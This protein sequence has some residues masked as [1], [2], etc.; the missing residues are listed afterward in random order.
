MSAERLFSADD[1]GHTPQPGRFERVRN[2]AVGVSEDGLERKPLGGTGL[3]VSALG[4]G[5][6]KLGAFWQ[7]RSPAE[8]RRAIDAARHAGINLFDT[9]D[10]YARGISER[11]LGR[12]FRGESGE[13]VLCT[14]VGLLKTPLAV[15]SARRSGARGHE[16]GLGGLARGGSAAGC[17]APRYLTVAL[18]RSLRRLGRD[19]VELLLLH[20]PPLDILERQEF[21]PALEALVLAGKVGH[22]GVSCATPDEADAALLV[23]GIACLQIPYSAARRT[24][25]GHVGPRAAEQGV[26]IMGAGPF[27]DS[28]LL[29]Q[30]ANRAG[31]LL[32]FA[33]AAPGVSSVLAGMSR[34]EHVEANVA[35]ALAPSPPGQA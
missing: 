13:L 30:D 19:R 23:P 15:A 14:K 22:F 17:Y 29:G 6:A 5:C 35:A 18:E 28:G 31:E 9:A 21:L 26:G 3:M 33:L 27:D 10:C 24:V 7:G 25:L 20:A 34:T 2:R 4:M 1:V 12:A 32:R 11:M 8:G 16:A